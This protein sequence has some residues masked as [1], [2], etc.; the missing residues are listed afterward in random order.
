MGTFV[1]KMFGEALPALDEHAD[2]GEDSAYV[3]AAGSVVRYFAGEHFRVCQNAL[4][5]L[6]GQAQKFRQYRVNGFLVQIFGLG[7]L[8][9]IGIQYV[10][11]GGADDFFHSIF[12]QWVD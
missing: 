5:V 8:V 7:R 4:A 10:L 11:V 1:G 3:A 6:V 9:G 2:G 12:F